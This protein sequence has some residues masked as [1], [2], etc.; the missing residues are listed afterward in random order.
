MVKRKHFVTQHQTLYKLCFIAAA[1]DDDD[2]D[3]KASLEVSE[4]LDCNKTC[5]S[6]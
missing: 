1:A 4:R 6:G 3:K 5:L 2:N